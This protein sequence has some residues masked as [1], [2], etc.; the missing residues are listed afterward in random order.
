MSKEEVIERFK[1]A[2]GTSRLGV[3]AKAQQKTFSGRLVDNRFHLS[4]NKNYR[5]SWT[6]EITGTIRSSDN[7]TELDVILKSNTF[8]IVFTIIFMII[9]LTMLVYEIIDFT[10]ISHF[11]LMTLGFA[12]FPYGLCWFGFNLDAGKSIDGLLKITKG[13]VK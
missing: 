6:P 8:V 3:F 9:G 5:N 10:D 1:E 2:I 7:S 13:E 4:L 11:S 12:I